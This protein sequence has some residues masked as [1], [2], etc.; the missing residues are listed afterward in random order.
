MP[1]APVRGSSTDQDTLH[2]TWESISSAAETGGSEIIYYSIYLNDDVNSIYQTSGTS[3]LY[4]KPPGSVET[5]QQ[6]RVAATNIYGTGTKSDLSLAIEFGSVPAKISGLVSSNIDSLNTRATIVWNNPNETIID[7]FFEV[8]N[9]NSNQYQDATSIMGDPTDTNV[10]FGVEFACQELV[11]NYGYQAGDTIV[12]RVNASN[13]VG[14]SEWSYPDSG[15]LE[16][17]TFSMLIL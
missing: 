8:L 16:A 7:Y 13:S 15:S 14:N 10:A 12:F 3:F 1:V 4:E 9:K 11:N 2:V 5:S 6:F 17:T